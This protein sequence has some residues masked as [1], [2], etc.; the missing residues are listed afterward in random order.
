MRAARA[1]GWAAAACASL[2]TMA[3]AAASSLAV[4]YNPT[5]EVRTVY[6]GAPLPVAYNQVAG[7]MPDGGSD[8]EGELFVLTPGKKGAGYT[9]TVV[10]TF[11]LANAATD[12]LSPSDNLV[13]D[14]AGNVWGTTDGNG[15][16]GTGTLFEMTKPATKGGSW[17]FNTV[18]SMP[19]AFYH[20]NA[21]A[22][23]GEMLFDPKGDL[24]GLIRG[25]LDGTAV[26]GIFEVTAANLAGGTGG[27]TIEYKFPSSDNA[28]PSGLVRDKHGNLFGV[29]QDGG[30]VIING[31]VG[32]GALWEVTPAKRGGWTRQNIH[33]FC[34][35][36]D[37]FGDCADGYSPVGPAAVDKNGV[38]YG[39]TYYGGAGYVVCCSFFSSGNGTIWSMQPPTSGGSG[40]FTI[41]HT[42]EDYNPDDSMTS[43]YRIHNP[44]GA[45]LSKSGQVLAATA[46]GG[47][48]AAGTANETPIDGGVIGVDPVG[49]ASTLVNND[50]AATDGA[51]QVAGPVTP[52]TSLHLDTKGRIYGATSSY[53]PNNGTGLAPDGVI[54]QITP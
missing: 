43:D 38:V 7:V 34:S 25:S 40:T 47:A 14:K 54:F 49:G 52:S 39:T 53:F 36:L 10:H 35:I 15:A 17:S 11:L 30:N 4:L 23:F 18:L 33:N 21:G 31:D 37:Q 50:F 26:G 3:P 5:D 42:L 13:A 1:A 9:K 12:G 20:N 32:A 28:Y 44:T 24:L 46:T 2:T 6:F 8:G 41:L 29:E 19:T 51:T 48:L 22:G 16:N 45:V 27:P